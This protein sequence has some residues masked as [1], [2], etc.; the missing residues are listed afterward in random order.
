MK[1]ETIDR[2]RRF[3]ADR[4]WEQ[5]HTPASLA[6]SIVI[7]AAELLECFQ[8]NEQ[9]WDQVHVAEELADVLVYS[10]NLL[11]ALGLDEDEIVNRKMEKNEKKYP[12]HLA[13]GNSKKYTELKVEAR[14]GTEKP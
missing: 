9:E 12:V 4:D 3:T 10:R 7:E 14:R 6:K 8:W 5:F 2:I 11:E 13:R 1:K